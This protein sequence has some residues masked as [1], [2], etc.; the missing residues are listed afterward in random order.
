MPS[1]LLTSKHLDSDIENLLRAGA[2]IKDVVQ[3]TGLKKT[4][5]YRMRK[6]LEI[7]GTVRAPRLPTGG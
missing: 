2:P 5:V 3:L 6:N 7:Y 4:L 1:N